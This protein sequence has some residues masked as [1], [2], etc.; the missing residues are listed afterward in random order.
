MLWNVLRGRGTRS[1]CHWGTTLSQR[2]NLAKSSWPFFTNSHPT[3]PAMFRCKKKGAGLPCQSP[4]TG[5]FSCIFLHARL[6]LLLLLSLRPGAAVAAVYVCQCFALLPFLQALIRF[7]ILLL[8]YTSIKHRHRSSSP[9]QA[10]CSCQL[11]LSMMK[12]SIESFSNDSRQGVGVEL[13]R[14]FFLRLFA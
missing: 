10:S 13:V 8:S 6:V 7:E 1:S 9:P 3:E 5:A 14:S 2:N 11:P 12:L 4:A